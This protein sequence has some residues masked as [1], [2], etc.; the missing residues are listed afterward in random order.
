MICPSPV[1]LACPVLSTRWKLDTT[2]ETVTSPVGTM[3]TSI[4][5]AIR[6]IGEAPTMAGPPV[7]EKS[8]TEVEMDGDGVVPGGGVGTGT[9]GGGVATCE[10]GVEPGAARPP[11]WPCGVV[12]GAGVLEGVT[13]EGF[14]V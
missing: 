10:E 11:A 4:G 1:L 5:R 12:T 6:I 9:A 3:E 2:V 14:A 13:A 7:G 8:G